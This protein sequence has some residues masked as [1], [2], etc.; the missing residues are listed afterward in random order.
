MKWGDGV[1]GRWGNSTNTPKP[2]NPKTQ[3]LSLVFWY[4]GIDF[5]TPGADATFNVNS[6]DTCLFEDSEGFS[7]TSPHL[8]MGDETIT[9]D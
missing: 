1:M 8:T 7:G 4:S 2:Q 6:F 9:V 5:A 3:G